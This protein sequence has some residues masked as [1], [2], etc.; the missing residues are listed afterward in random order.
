[1]RKGDLV[2]FEKDGEVA[3]E[4][5]IRVVNKDEI[6]V[7][8]FFKPSSIIRKDQVIKVISR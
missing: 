2:K 3:T 6:E 1:M 4:M 7:Q 5:I 8:S